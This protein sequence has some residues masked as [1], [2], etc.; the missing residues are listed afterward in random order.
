M[1]TTN[2]LIIALFLVFSFN[3]MA[4]SLESITLKDNSV[5]TKQEIFATHFNLDKSVDFVEL[6]D[7]SKIE[8]SEINHINFNINP[9]FGVQT[10]AAVRTG[11]DG[12]GG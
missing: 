3:A 7:G 1:K 2:K 6:N 4:I 5:V 11:G 9:K 12:S 8:G 10:R